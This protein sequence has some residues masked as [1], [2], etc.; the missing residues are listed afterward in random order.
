MGFG[1]WAFFGGG[2]GKEIEADLDF[3]ARFNFFAFQG[4]DALFEEMAIEVEA[5]SG[6]VAAL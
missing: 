3:D 1:F 5:D 4:R 2:E 6:D